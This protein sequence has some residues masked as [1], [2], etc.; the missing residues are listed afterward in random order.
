MALLVTDAIVLHSME[1]LESSRI[2]RLITREGGLQA[3]IAKGA[4]RPRSRFGAALDLFAEGSAQILVKPGR[5]LQTLTGFDVT[6][7]RHAL[8]EDL[9]RFN[10]A[11]AIAEIVLRFAHDDAGAGI[12]D[13]VEH[14]LDDVAAAPAGT[15]RER[16]VGAIWRIVG[17]LGFSPSLDACSVCHAPV[18]VGEAVLFHHR[19][20]GILCDRCARSHGG[21][22]AIPRE[23]LD[24]LRAWLGGDA[25][26]ALGAREG[27][28][29]QRLLHEFV[30]EHL[31]EGRAVRAFDAW[32]T[33]AADA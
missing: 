14:A 2:L 31:A 28:A 7:A 25:S 23:A 33:A 20:G 17:A 16:T 12:Y 1:Y 30:R 10:G 9:G 13:I 15:A 8:A 22:R 5:D 24:A 4:R 29:H 19:A 26:P 3:V 21:G 11:A 32:A 18:A 6:R 27:R